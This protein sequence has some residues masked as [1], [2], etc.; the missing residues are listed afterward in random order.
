MSSLN[1]SVFVI[2][3]NGFADTI[4]A[5]NSLLAQTIPTQIFLLD[6]NSD[7]FEGENLKSYFAENNN[8]HVF[9]SAQNLG[10]A[11]GCNYLLQKSLTIQTPEFV[12]LLNNDA[13]TEPNW[14]E[15]LVISAQ[16][17]KADAVASKMIQFR[18]RKLLDNAG[19]FMLNTG[20][21]IPVGHGE[22]IDFHNQTKEVV[23]ACGG[24]CLYRYKMIEQ[25]GFFDEHFF[26]G[27]EDAE[28]GLR[29]LICG[30]KQVYEPTA[31]VYHKMSESIKKIFDYKYTL[32]IQSDIFY[33][34]FK[35]MPLGFLW[36][37][38]PFF[39]FKYFTVL[40]I[41]VLFFRVK[42]LKV[43]FNSFFKLIFTNRIKIIKARNKF[44]KFNSVKLSWWKIQQQTV[45]FLWFDAKR[46]VKYVILR[47]P[48]QFEKY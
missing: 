31:I 43:L 32:R 33:S 26:V 16:K 12:L 46:F 10:F 5:V 4:E 15:N 39:V 29:A 18:N 30:Y 6:N 23:G 13:I 48:T 44:Q 21:V 1:I 37:N 40:V 7:N 2:N 8:I 38:L 36:V 11:K 34:Y 22:P 42:F 47:N 20:E 9:L 17:N 28:F 35:L 3:F 25:I 41:D 24:A 45:F 14:V 27:Y 19:H